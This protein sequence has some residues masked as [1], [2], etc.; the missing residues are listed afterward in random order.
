M[1]LFVTSTN[2]SYHIFTYANEK[3]VC[4]F[5]RVFTKLDSTRPTF[6]NPATDWKN[7][8]QQQAWFYAVCVSALNRFGLVLYMT[9]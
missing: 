1:L 7:V 9:S 8:M 5:V 3:F 2:L 4:V 6:A